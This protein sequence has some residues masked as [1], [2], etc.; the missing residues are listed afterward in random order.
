M[1]TY[2]QGTLRYQV[3]DKTYAVPVYMD[4]PEADSVVESLREALSDMNYSEGMVEYSPLHSECRY[5][6][7]IVSPDDD[8]ADFPDDIRA[9]LETCFTPEFVKNYKES[10]GPEYEME[11]YTDYEMVEE[12]DRLILKQVTR[13]RIKSEKRQVFDEEGRPVKIRVRKDG[14]IVTRNM[15]SRVRVRK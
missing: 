10:Q 15:V 5:N 2:T 9:F 7:E 11:T 1:I 8:L 3:G 6:G 14:K 12:G 13:E 4:L